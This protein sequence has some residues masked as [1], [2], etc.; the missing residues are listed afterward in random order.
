MSEK[1]FKCDICDKEYKSRGGLFY[2]K[3]IKH[4]DIDK[5]KEEYK[6]RILEILQVNNK[7]ENMGENE[8]EGIIN[9]GDDEK[10][11]EVV[12]EN[13][14]DNK[15]IFSLTTFFYKKAI[16]GFVNIFNLNSEKY[17]IN[18]ETLNKCMERD[19]EK[20]EECFSEIYAKNEKY[21]NLVEKLEKYPEYKLLTITST[22]IVESLEVN[23]NSNIVINEI[24]NNDENEEIKNEEGRDEKDI[25]S[26]IIGRLKKEL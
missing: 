11:I 16:S 2:H 9:N 24:K 21:R 4:G 3:K 8:M 5:K 7:S 1:I 22:H 17:K 18:T 15:S 23:N 10:I 26:L 20:I 25:K 19:N 12:E 6:Q 14:N 13:K